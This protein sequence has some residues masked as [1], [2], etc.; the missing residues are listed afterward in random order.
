MDNRNS[1]NSHHKDKKKNDNYEDHTDYKNY[2]ISAT[3][4]IRTRTAPAEL[5]A[6][7]GSAESVATAALLMATAPPAPSRRAGADAGAAE[8]PGVAGGTGGLHGSR[9]GEGSGASWGCGREAWR[10][11]ENPTAVAVGRSGDSRLGT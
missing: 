8:G 11:A 2:I 5:G 6:L 9:R 1:K 3:R 10:F 4:T 7:M